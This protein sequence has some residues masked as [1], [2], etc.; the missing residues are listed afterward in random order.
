MKAGTSGGLEAWKPESLK[1]LIAG[2]FHGFQA[3]QPHSF[4][5]SQLPSLIASQLPSLQASH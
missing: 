3:S 2:M 5:A 1:A 4:L